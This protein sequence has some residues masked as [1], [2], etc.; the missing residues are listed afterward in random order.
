MK[1]FIRIT[2]YVFS[3]TLIILTSICLI[4]SMI[5]SSYAISLDEKLI[6]AV[7]KQA[8]EALSSKHQMRY[9]GSGGGFKNNKISMSALSFTIVKPLNK[10]DARHLIVDSIHEFLKTI[11][12]NNELS[13]YLLNNPFTINNIEL[14][15]FTTLP[16]GNSYYDPFLSVVCT[17]NGKI[18]YRSY[19]PDK[20]YHYKIDDV[21]TFEEALQILAKEKLTL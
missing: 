17:H 14:T 21:E 11:N 15:I 20:K 13:P 9:Q 4:L 18:Y 5:S 2:L 19:D 10:H 7:E 3:T 8:G 16:N 1:I 12:D 6:L